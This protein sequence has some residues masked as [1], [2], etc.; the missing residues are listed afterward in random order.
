[1]GDPAGIGPE[2]C[3]RLLADTKVA[4]D[5]VPIVFGDAGVLSRVADKCS[6]SLPSTILTLKEFERELKK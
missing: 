5:C 3:L 6:L 2:L 1:M 4:N